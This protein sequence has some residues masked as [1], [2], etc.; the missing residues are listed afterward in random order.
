MFFFDENLPL[1]KEMDKD[2]ENYEL[3]YSDSDS[4]IYIYMIK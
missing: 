1:R 3:A 2:K 4:G